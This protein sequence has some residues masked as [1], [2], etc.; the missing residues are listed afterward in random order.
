MM[1]TFVGFSRVI[2]KQP[3]SLNGK[4]FLVKS[5]KS[6]EISRDEDDRDDGMT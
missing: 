5:V 2:V 3:C 1:A 6:R 4:K